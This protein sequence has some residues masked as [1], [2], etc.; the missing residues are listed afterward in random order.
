LIITTDVFINIPIT[1]NTHPVININGDN[2]TGKV[3]ES[4]WIKPLLNYGIGGFTIKLYNPK[5]I[6]SGLYGVGDVVNCYLDNVDGTYLQFTGRIDFPREVLNKEG[7]FL[8]IVGR[9]VSYFLSERRVSY[10]ASDMDCGTVLINLITLYAPECT[11]NNVSL[12]GVNVDVSY[13]YKTFYEAVTDL[14]E[15]SGFDCYIDNNLDFHFFEANTIMNDDEC[16]AEGDNFIETQEN[17]SDDYYEKTR[18]TVIGQDDVGIPIVYTAING[19]DDSTT[20]REDEGIREVFIRNTSIS[21]MSDASTTAIAELSKYTNRPPQGR[22]KSFGLQTLNQGD[23]FWISVP[24][25]HIYG[26]Y[27]ALEVTHTFGTKMGGWRTEVITEFKPQDTKELINTVIRKNETIMTA[28]NFNK[29]NYSYNIPFS[30]DSLT[31]SIVD[32]EITNGSLILTVGSTTGTWIS[33]PK[34]SFVNITKVELRIVGSNLNSSIF[35]ISSDGGITYQTITNRILTS[36]A[37]TGTN[38]VVKV[39]LNT[40]FGASPEIESMAVLFS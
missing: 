36:V 5:G 1:R 24:R 17:G 28:D 13:D 14:M 7:Q 27:K 32:C 26:I 40:Y 18:V 12:S 8:E 16:I 37:Q 21:T 20:G 29:L 35:Q 38:L 4:T 33:V 9:H 25:Q 10:V 39:T 19:L 3:V 2:L 11:Y 22:F 15:K 30:D 31:G 34:T 23:N 6:L